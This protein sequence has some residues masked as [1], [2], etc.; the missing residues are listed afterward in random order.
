MKGLKE[1]FERWLSDETW[2]WT[3]YATLT[4]SRPMRKG[5]LHFGR[6]WAR[7]IA[8]TAPKLWGFIFQETH[9]DGQRLHLH[10]L[11]SVT[12]NLVGEP[13]NREMWSWWFQKFGRALVVDVRKRSQHTEKWPRHKKHEKIVNEF[14]SPL[15]RYLTKYMVKEAYLATFDWDF[16]AFADGSELTSEEFHACSG[17]MPTFLEEN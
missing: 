2:N 1:E 16:Y 10:A 9:S 3:T 8:R 13:T 11:F 5:A 14:V 17:V 12:P 6:A 7:F 4:F 15:A